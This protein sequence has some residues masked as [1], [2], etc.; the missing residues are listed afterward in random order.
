MASGKS[1]EILTGDQAADKRAAA[2]AWRDAGSSPGD[3]VVKCDNN[4]VVDL[5]SA[6]NATV[7]ARIYI[8]PPFQMNVHTCRVNVTTKRVAFF[9]TS[10]T[11]IVYEVDF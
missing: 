4:T 2:K 6:N 11:F 3:V 10:N 5:V 1:L 7:L 8:T 9:T